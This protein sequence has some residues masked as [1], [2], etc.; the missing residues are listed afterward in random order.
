MTLSP[1]DQRVT[2]EPTSV[3]IPADSPPGTKGI[4]GCIWYLPWMMRTSGKLRPAAFTSLRTSLGPNSGVSQ[5]W[6]KLSLSGSPWWTLTTSIFG[7]LIAGFAAYPRKEGETIAWA[8]LLLL[9]PLWVMLFGVFGVAPVVTRTSEVMPLLRN[10]VGFL[11]GG[12]AA[13]LI[14][15]ATVGQK[16]Q[17]DAEG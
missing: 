7:G 3:T 4:G 8:W 11:A 13:Y 9:S 10:G 2:A 15:Q 14:A 12:I 5:S 1:T 17:N 6:T 16:L